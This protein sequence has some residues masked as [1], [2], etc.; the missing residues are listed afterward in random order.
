MIWLH[1]E[2]EFQLGTLGISTVHTHYSDHPIVSK[3]SNEDFSLT[4]RFRSKNKY[5][6]HY[7]ELH[8]WEMLI[9]EITLSNSELELWIYTYPRG[10]DTGKGFQVRLLSRRLDHQIGYWQVQQ[11]NVSIDN[12]I[13]I[14]EYVWR[15]S[16]G[17]LLM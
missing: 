3:F 16:N 10:Y 12:L 11:I 14:M 9:T 2:H 17:N 4:N 13:N 6:W 5:V 8:F 1:K 15:C 7:R